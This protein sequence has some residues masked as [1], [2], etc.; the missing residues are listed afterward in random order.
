MM[1]I[2]MALFWHIYW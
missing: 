1:L 2:M